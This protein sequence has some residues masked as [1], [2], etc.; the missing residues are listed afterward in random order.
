M[1]CAK[2]ATVSALSIFALALTACGDSS[3]ELERKA[4]QQ[5]HNQ[6]MTI[7]HEQ[8]RL[9]AEELNRIRDAQRK[10][11][12]RYEFVVTELNRVQREIEDLNR[13]P[14]PL[15]GPLLVRWNKALTDFAFVQ[16]VY[17]EYNALCV[18]K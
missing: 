16:S 7:L 18:R 13:Y 17:N 2:A 3:Y 6:M 12:E 5:Q 4:K 10:C 9:E 11:Q 8:I 14:R 15:Q 1:H